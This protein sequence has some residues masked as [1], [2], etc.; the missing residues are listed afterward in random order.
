[1]GREI[2]SISQ[3]VRRSGDQ[4]SFLLKKEPPDLLAS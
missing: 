2:R 4:N 3:E 1:M